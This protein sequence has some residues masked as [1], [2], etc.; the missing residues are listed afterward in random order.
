MILPVVPYGHETLSLI[1]KEERRLRV[2]ENRVPRR[3][4]GPK[5]DEVTGGWRQLH[6]ELRNLHSSPSIIRMMK[7]RRM[8]CAGHVAR[9]RRRR[10]HIGY[11]LQNSKG[12]RP[13]ERSRRR[14]WTKLKWILER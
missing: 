6:N 2:F 13:L 9:M 8:R 14:F 10:M 1:L 11:W 4:Y 5:R 3:M 7:S 12:K